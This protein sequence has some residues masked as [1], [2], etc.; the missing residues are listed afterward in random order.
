MRNAQLESSDPACQRLTTKESL[1]LCTPNSSLIT[2]AEYQSREIDNTLPIGPYLDLAIFLSGIIKL[3]T[4]ADLVP[5]A[6]LEIVRPTGNGCAICGVALRKR[7]D[8]ANL[9]VGRITRGLIR[10]ENQ[11]KSS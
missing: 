2:I 8:V 10:L 3:H 5:S 9:L 6:N 7:F 11:F 1:H 4:L